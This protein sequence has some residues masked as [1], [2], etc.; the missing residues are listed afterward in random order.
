MAKHVTVSRIENAAQ[1]QH[2]VSHTKRVND[3][4]NFAHFSNNQRLN[5]D[6][7]GKAV[8]NDRK[9]AVDYRPQ[10]RPSS[11]S[12]KGV[13]R[14]KNAEGVGFYDHRHRSAERVNS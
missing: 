3:Y 1:V 10:N 11:S 5:Y 8:G 6:G 14:R 4:S 9:A 7:W 13:G 2:S 12:V